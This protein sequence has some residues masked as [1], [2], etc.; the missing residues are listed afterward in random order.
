[1]CNVTF[2]DRLRSYD[3]RGKLIFR[4]YKMMCAKQETLMVWLEEWMKVLGL[5]VEQ[6]K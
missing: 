4:Q 3:L 6:L 2:K 5:N 1:M